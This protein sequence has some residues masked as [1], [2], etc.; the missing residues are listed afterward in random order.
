MSCELEIAALEWVGRS[1]RERTT[2][3]WTAPRNSRE[4]ARQELGADVCRGERTHDR[5]NA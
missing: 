5:L 4:G 3:A 2:S 1:E